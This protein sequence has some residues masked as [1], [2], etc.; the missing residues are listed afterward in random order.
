MNSLNK[1]F[2]K[3]ELETMY[4]DAMAKVAAGNVYF[5]YKNPEV[6]YIVVGHAIST[7][8]LEP[9]VIYG[10]LAH[11]TEFVWSRPVS[12]WF[13]KVEV[14]GKLVDRFTFVETIEDEDFDDEEDFE[15]EEE[16]DG[17][18]CK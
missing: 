12:Q 7:Q 5:H 13:E 8:T 18:D 14:D 10:E 11:D 4:K 9:V 2:S 6:K 1:K 3:A 17:E 16:C 15:D